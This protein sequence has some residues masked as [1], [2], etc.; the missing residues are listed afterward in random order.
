M[1]TTCKEMIDLLNKA[2]CLATLQLPRGN[3][4]IPEVERMFEELKQQLIT[5]L[6]DAE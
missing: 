6:E 1:T 5:I 3:P 2:N 4:N